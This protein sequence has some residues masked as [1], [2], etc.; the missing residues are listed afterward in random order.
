VDDALKQAV[1]AHRAGRLAEARI[2][3]Q[4]VLSERP[5]DPD[6]LNFLGM[7]EFQGGE[8]ERGIALLRQSL[9]QA[10]ANPHAWLNMGN[11]LVGQAGPE[12][13]LTA[14]EQSLMLLPDFP[15]A[16]YNRG[17]CERRL[18]RWDAAIESLSR[19]VALRP[20]YGAAC[21]SLGSLLYRLN[22][23]SESAKVYREWLAA[24]PTHPVARHMAAAALGKN[25]P[26]RASPEYVTWLFDRFADAFDESLAAL[27]YRAPQLVAE[28][29]AVHPGCRSGRLKVLDAGCG[30]GLCGPCLRSTARELVGVDLSPAMVEKARA[31]AIYDHLE[32]AEL[33]AYMSTQCDTYD[34][35]V[36][37]DTLC[38]IG[39][40]D[41]VFEAAVSALGA[42]GLFIFTVESLPEDGAERFRLQT[43][44]RYAHA[45]NYVRQ[46]LGRFAVVQSL[47]RIILRRERGADVS[48]LLVVARALI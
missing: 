16:W 40:L 21:E 37:A 20:S 11:M 31:R 12:A 38:Y 23:L 19:A 22:R 33:T 32:V 15:E 46:C 28:A 44:G 14:Y 13:A 45:E 29:L 10:P 26:G 39:V 1:S 34:A 5:Q 43:H 25:I 42:G 47:D 24:D 17:V 4:A 7:L 30:T 18:R 48:G 2:A 9:E 8:G 3:Y 6:A 41:E 36:S 27:A 35:I